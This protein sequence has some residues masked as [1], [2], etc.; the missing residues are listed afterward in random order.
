MERL[1]TENLTFTQVQ[2]LP[3]VKHYARKIKLVETVDAMVDSQMHL[4]AGLAV[5]AMV[6]DTLSGRTPLYRLKD[7]FAENDTELLLGTR[8]DPERLCDYNLARV[9][10]RIYEAGTQK[11]FTQL[12]QNAIG[13][14]SIDTGRLHY[15]TTS[16]SVYGDY[17]MTEPFNITYGH[18]KDKRP[19]LKQFLISMLCVDRNIPIIGT[20]EDGNASDKTLN[21]R[22]LSGICEHMAGHGIEAG[23]YIET[24]RLPAEDRHPYRGAGHDTA[25]IPSDLAPDGAFHATAHCLRRIDY[26]LETQTNEKADRLYDDHQVPACARGHF[27]QPQT[28]CKAD[29]AG[30]A[31]ISQGAQCR[32]GGLYFPMTAKANSYEYRSVGCGMYDTR[33]HHRLYCRPIEMVGMR[34]SA[35]RQRCVIGH[36]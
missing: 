13:G 11:I 36:P 25:H 28:A 34:F 22:L 19:D 5:M 6:L 15:D 23:A 21:N 30:A 31:G 27:R 4:S 29:D 17:E 35:V 18:S 33:R 32:T 3:I 9:L 10:D 16:I 20:P 1:K 24:L 14:F 8:V 26:R 2:H 7:A 12:A